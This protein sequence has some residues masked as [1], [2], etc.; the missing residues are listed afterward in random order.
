MLQ[1]IDML[2]I[3][4]LEAM[5]Y[6]RSSVRLRAYGQR[7]PL[8]EYKN[9]GLK[10]FRV[11]EVSIDNTIAEMVLRAGETQV[12]RPRQTIEI[13]PFGAVLGKSQGE[14]ASAGNRQSANPKPAAGRNDP[15]P[16]GSGKKYKKCHG[17]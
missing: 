12:P 14:G 6:M 15:C 8:V 11:L 9:E 4:H 7:D 16:C 5:D 17:K 2:W 1:A 13:H 10:L 3:E